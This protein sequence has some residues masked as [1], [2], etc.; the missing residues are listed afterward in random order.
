MRLALEPEGRGPLD[1][2][3]GVVPDARLRDH[4]RRDVGIVAGN[5]DTAR[6]LIPE[7]VARGHAG[8]KDRD[9]EESHRTPHFN[10]AATAARLASVCAM[11]ATV[12]NRSARLS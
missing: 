1:L 10:S 4:E 5:S 3:V 11:S 12:A 2:A 8:V 6:R 7:R 9:R